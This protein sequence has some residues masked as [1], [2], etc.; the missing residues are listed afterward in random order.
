MAT[1]DGTA[2]G[3]LSVGTSETAGSAE[4]NAGPE[5]ASQAALA[6]S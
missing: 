1:A 3:P 5:R 6:P 2:R 4:I